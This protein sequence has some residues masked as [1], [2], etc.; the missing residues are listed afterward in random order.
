MDKQEQ[1]KKQSYYQRNKTKLA[2]YSKNYYFK[3]K[4]TVIKKNAGIKIERNVCIEL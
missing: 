3:K 1:I 2:E 4:N